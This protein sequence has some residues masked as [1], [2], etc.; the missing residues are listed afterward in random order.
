MQS[1]QLRPV[2]ANPGLTDKVY[3]ALRDAI[4]RMDIYRGDEPPKLDER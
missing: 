2:K 4:S 3:V 1:I